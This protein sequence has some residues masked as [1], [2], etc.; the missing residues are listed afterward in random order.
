MSTHGRTADT[1]AAPRD[2][3]LL[4]GSGAVAV[5]GLPQ[6]A[7]LDA[8]GTA[9]AVHLTAP[10]D[11]PADPGA[12]LTWGQRALWI[13]IRRHGASHAMFS[14]RRVVA[15]PRRTAL[16]VPSALR[17]VSALVA[18]H[19]SLRTR[20]QEVDGQLRQV[21]AARGEQPV[22]VIPIGAPPADDGAALAVQVAAE[23]AS[24]PFD[25]DREW[26]QRI[27]LLVAGER[28]CR[29]ALVFSHTTVDFRAAELV[30]RDLRLLLLRGA[31]PTPP[32]AQSADIARL[33]DS[34]RLQRRNARAVRYWLDI[35]H[36]LPADTLPGVGPAHS[37]R[38]QRCVLTSPA[39]DTAA[40]TVARR[41]RVSTSTVLLSAVAGVIAARS[42]QDTCGIYTMVNNR[43]A[44]EY[45]E[46]ISKLNQLGLLVISLADRPAFAEALPR[47]WHAALEAYRH[48]YY[49]PEQMAQAHEAAGLPYATGVNKHCYFNDIRL[50]P[51][52]EL[53]GDG[54]DAVA[55]RAAMAATS[56]A[57]AEG[58]ETFTW[59]M[60]VEVIDTPG[61]MG[62]AVTGDTAHLPP[63]VAERFLRAVERLLVDAALGPLPW[64]WT[65]AASPDL[66]TT[67]EPVAP[68]RRA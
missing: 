1:G 37:P 5:D 7:E 9:H 10:F 46:A 50:A 43:S 2:T 64:P 57:V 67:P 48:A 63:D 8:P 6:T 56:F 42:G 66:P 65:S 62:L 55:L 36:R 68:V 3:V 58:L 40:R 11:G 25:H 54:L 19:S 29:I 35:H 61:G 17:A 30:L 34:D 44:D 23:L 4:A 20:V 49:D 13:A 45:R 47:V 60:R 27:A 22:L 39:A 14:L 26:P 59:L 28:V 51:E 41:E 16:D 15:A 52:A 12:P 21:V 53:P 31:V 33:E 24:T 32:P 18:R 38:F